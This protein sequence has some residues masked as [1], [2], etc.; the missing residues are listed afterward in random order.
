MW[1]NIF[2]SFV[3]ALDTTSNILFVKSSI[4]LQQFTYNSLCARPKIVFEVGWGLTLFEKN[5]REGSHF[6]NI[7][8]VIEEL[9]IH[10]YMCLT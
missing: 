10:V 4:G 9:K 8:H 2:R 5:L 1:G 7:L 3:R 6:L